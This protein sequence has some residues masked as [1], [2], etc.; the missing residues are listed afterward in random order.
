MTE[1]IAGAFQQ[2]RARITGIL[3][4]L[5][6]LTAICA[7]VFVGKGRPGLYEVVFLISNAFY[8]AVTLL[9]YSLFKPVNMSISTLAALLS[10]LGCAASI[11][12]FLHLAPYNINPLI[13]FGPFCILIGYL[14]LNSSFLP[15][16]IGALMVLAGVGWLIYLFPFASHIST[17]LKILGI[18]AEGSL[19]L[20]LTAMGVNEQRWKEQAAAAEMRA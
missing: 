12:G 5:Y 18:V 1:R 10:L 14:I 15:R 4:L 8:V 6:F 16:I 11:L 9:F 19:M 20:W 17:Y 2:S 13:F 7:E 3:Y